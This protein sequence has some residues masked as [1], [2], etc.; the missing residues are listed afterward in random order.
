MVT[1][2]DIMGN[3]VYRCAS[4]TNSERQFSLNLP[5]GVYV[6]SVTEGANSYYARLVIRN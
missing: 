5:D 4:K 3:E 6:V 1:V 2:H